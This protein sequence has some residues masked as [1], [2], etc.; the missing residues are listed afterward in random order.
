MRGPAWAELERSRLDG[1]APGGAQVYEL[2]RPVRR[3]LGEEVPLLNVRSEID[4][5]RKPG[6]IS[7][8]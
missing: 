7:V 3:R 8:R 5:A 6:Q 2:E 4:L 1:G